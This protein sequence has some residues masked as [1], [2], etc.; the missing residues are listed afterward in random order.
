MKIPYVL[1]APSYPAVVP[2]DVLTG[3]RP[4]LDTDQVPREAQRLAER[5]VDVGWQV[6]VTYAE[7]YGWK[8]VREPAPPEDKRKWVMVPKQYVS[9]SVAVRLLDPGKEMRI[10]IWVDSK[11]ATGL[12]LLP[13][14][15]IKVDAAA[16]KDLSG[17]P[18]SDLGKHRGDDGAVVYHG[19]GR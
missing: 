14:G 7:A 10:A 16:I 18:H 15:L 11:F 19:G 12:R 3:A 17:S 5:A 1:R 4:S 9:V 2:G 8:R 6:L 13:Q